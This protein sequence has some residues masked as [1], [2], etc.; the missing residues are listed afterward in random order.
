METKEPTNPLDKLFVYELGARE[1]A[2]FILDYLRIEREGLK[3]HFF[4]TLR[5]SVK[6]KILLYLLALRVLY[7]QKLRVGNSA[8]PTT[9]ANDLEA[10][11]GTIRPILK[12]LLDEHLVYYDAGESLYSIPLGGIDKAMKYIQKMDKNA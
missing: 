2:A 7:S 1:I 11:G 10:I 4:P 3:I 5:I 12:Q 9:I 6:Q 8:N